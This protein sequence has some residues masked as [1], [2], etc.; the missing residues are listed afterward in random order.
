MSTI[1]EP[2]EIERRADA[3]PPFE[4]GMRLT[5]AEFRRLWD[6]HPEIIHA[7]R[8]DGVVDP[9]TEKTVDVVAIDDARGTLRIR[10]AQNRTDEPLPAAL[11]SELLWKT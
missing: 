8:I 9:V 4:A 5:R 7:E 2:L 10:R 3:P 6:L 1:T 11:T